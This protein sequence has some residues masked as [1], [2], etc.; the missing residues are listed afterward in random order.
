VALTAP[1]NG[2]FYILDAKSGKLLSAKPLVQDHLASAYE[3]QSAKP[4]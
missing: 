1:K 4:V 2:F 3:L